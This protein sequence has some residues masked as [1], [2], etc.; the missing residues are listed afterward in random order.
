[1]TEEELYNLSD[2]ELEAAFK[3]AKAD[4]DSPEI[5]IE[6]GTEEVEYQEEDVVDE[7]LEQPE[8]QDSDD[9]TSND[10]EVEEEE[11]E[12]SDST[13]DD[14]DG[15][16][17]DEEEQTEDE[18]DEAEEDLQP[19]EKIKV[20]ANGKDFE[21]TLEEMMEKFP[22]TFSQ[23]HD[24]TKKMQAMKP[25]RKSIDAME[26]NNITHEDINLLID[27]RKGDKAAIAE[28]LKKTGVDALELDTDEA[29]TPKD[30]GRDEHALAIKDVLDSIQNDKEYEVTQRILGKEWDD[31]SW[32]TVS[33]N[34][35]FIKGLHIDVQSGLYDK[36]A[37]IAEKLKFYDGGKKSDLDYYG[38]AAA[39]YAKEQNEAN[40][41][42][43][44]LKER[45]TKVAEAE[46][47]AE[48]KEKS[49][50][51]TVVKQEAKARKAAAPTRKGAGK[52]GVTNY[53]DTS[54]EDFDE[55]YSKL[56]QP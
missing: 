43:Q 22:A 5:E 37:P 12:D 9:D 21:F 30:Y 56:E 49:R 20:R 27:L 33:E 16:S 26:Q 18:T 3:E 41:R 6:S 28:L 47:I 44:A 19:V 51:A 52:K 2:E 54:D 36:L 35:Q 46:R 55:W 31:A 15:D 38:E 25:W 34:P 45:D 24:Y 53:L 17:E 23:A 14:L 8:E 13:E 1:M 7:D 39:Q 40:T 42:A 10:D 29:Y 11:S 48:V 50:K 32:K 4:F